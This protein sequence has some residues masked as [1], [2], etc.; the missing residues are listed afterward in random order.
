[1]LA[2]ATQEPGARVPLGRARVTDTLARAAAGA[3]LSEALAA[4]SPDNITVLLMLLQ[5][6]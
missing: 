4:G 3:L 6:D 1:M 5:W 2:V